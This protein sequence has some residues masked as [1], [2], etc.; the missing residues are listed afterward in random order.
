[1][2][3]VSDQ[4]INK[5]KTKNTT[6]TNQQCKWVLV[7]L[8]C[9][10]TVAGAHG[11]HSGT[12]GK[13]FSSKNINRRRRLMAT[14]EWSHLR[15]FNCWRVSFSNVALIPFRVNRTN[16]EPQ[17]A[18]KCVLNLTTRTRYNCWTIY[19]SRYSPFWLFFSFSTFMDTIFCQAVGMRVLSTRS[20]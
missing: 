7:V 8:K 16:G 12:W 17:C 13:S 20:D 3:L 1:M 11:A 15:E 4:L 19:Y 5:K 10:N 14:L 6:Q 9:A 18:P 2:F